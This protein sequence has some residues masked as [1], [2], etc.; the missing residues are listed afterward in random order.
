MKPYTSLKSILAE[1]FPLHRTLVSDDHDKTLEI[2]GSYM[3]DSS[4][5]TIETYAPL[6]QVWT[7]KVPERYVVHE[8]YLEIE[9]GERVVDF[10]DNPLHIVSYS[11]PVD[12]ILSFD[13]LQPHLYFNWGFCLPKNVF[14]KLPRDKK[15][16]AV[17][18]SEF[19]TDPKQGF[20]VAT[21]VVHPEGGPNPEAGEFLVQAH[22]CHPMQANDDGA[23]VVSTIELARRLVEK[24][25]P[26]GSMSVRFWF[27]P[28]TIGTI[29]WLAHNESLI[30]NLRGGIFMEMTGNQNKIA[31]HHTRQHNHLLDKVTSYVLRDTDH[32][33]RD[34]A[35]APA[36]D[37]RVINGPG[38]NVPCISINRFPYDEYHTTDDNLDIM[39]EDML[40]GS[41]QTA[42]EIIRIYASNY[43]P[44]RT[45]R[46][47]VFLS[48]YGLWVDWR[49][50]W[51]LN[52]AIE[53]IMMRFEGQHTIFD[54]AEQVGLDYW[55]VRDYV[56]KFR[57]KGF[58]NPL[59]IPFE[60]QKE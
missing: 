55:T 44:K 25:L 13:E 53:K 36:N 14:D 19:V 1:F 18:R 43:T 45:F 29:A 41:A 27:G 9:G 2:V 33:S 50:N 39:H 31:W 48:G 60:G 58:V 5:Y 6:T 40:V 24:P 42:E 54:I 22:T 4:N 52:R 35:A 34:F 49:E 16:H 51:A 38:V 46:G 28:E 17:I 26:A 21:A 7:W 32:E 15:Y 37:E 30:P 47:P 11:L 3:P 23:G 12:K 56:E 20:K 59:P 8:A 57:A 10:K